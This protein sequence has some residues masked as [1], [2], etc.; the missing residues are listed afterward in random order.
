[1]CGPFDDDDDGGPHRPNRPD[2]FI[3]SNP[4][5]MNQ[6]FSSSWASASAYASSSYSRSAC[7]SFSSSTTGHHFGGFRQSFGLDG[8]CS[9]F[10]VQFVPRQTCTYIIEW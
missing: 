5:P 4:K 1:M 10:V 6:M 8:N 7:W 9:N 3:P 2:D